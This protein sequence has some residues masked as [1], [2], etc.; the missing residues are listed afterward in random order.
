MS[1]NSHK[2][3][4]EN[5]IIR[6]FERSEIIL[7]WVN[8]VP[9]LV[10]ILT[11]AL[12]ILSRFELFIPPSIEAIRIIHKIAGVLWIA[13][14]G[15]SFFFVGRELNIDNTRDQFKIGLSDVSWAIKAVRS[16][17]NR[18]IEVPPVGKFN[19]G[20]K[21]N[22]ILVIVYVVAFVGSGALIWA[23]KTM[24]FPWYFHAAVFFMAIF[25]LGG[26]LY[27]SFVHPSTRPGLIGIFNG[28]VPKSYIIHHHSLMIE[29]AANARRETTAKKVFISTRTERSAQKP[30]ST[31]VPDLDVLRTRDRQ[32]SK[33]RH[34]EL[35]PAMQTCHAD[36]L[37][38]GPNGFQRQQP[39]L[40]PDAGLAIAWHEGHGRGRDDD[41]RVPAVQSRSADARAS[42]PRGFQHRQPQPDPD[43][44]LVAASPGGQGISRE[45]IDMQKAWGR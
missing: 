9:F 14:I 32:K 27:L 21:I 35:V 3:A 42:S 16:F 8:A 41:E 23:Y 17:F 28:M 34:M 12:N 25:S 19:V 33:Y 13:G 6:R 40:D 22:A 29:G 26:H 31:M 4:E 30:D 36:G 44:C 39:Q 10:L 2:I 24:L 45:E 20:Q 11:G 5:K 43:A 1:S 38:A 37:A 15:Y 7:H 18:H